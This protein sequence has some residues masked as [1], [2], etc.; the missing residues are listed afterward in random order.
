MRALLW[1]F[2]GLM[3]HGP[4][5]HADVFTVG[6][7]A[8]CTHASV[9]AAINA[10]LDNGNGLDVINVARN[11][12]Y[13]AQA[14]VAQNDTLVIQG[15]FTDCS[16]ATGDPNLPTVISGAG[17]SAAP[18]LRIQGNGNVT[19]RNLVL[20]DGDAPANADGGGLSI[21]DGPHLITL[22]NVRLANN[23][24]GRGAGMAVAS[25]MASVTVTLQG[26]SRIFGNQASSDGGGIY[27]LNSNLSLVTESGI[28]NSN[29]SGRDGGGIYAENCHTD[30]ASGNA[31]GLLWNNQSVRNG[32]GIYAFGSFSVTRVYSLFA[33]A[34]TRLGANV[35]AASGGAIYA[36]D[37]ADVQLQNIEIADNTAQDGGGIFYRGSS[38]SVG[39]DLTIASTGVADG[40]VDC[41]LGS[42]CNRFVDNYSAVGGVPADGVAAI[43]WR[44]EGSA[45]GRA[46]INRASFSGNQGGRVLDSFVQ[47]DAVTKQ[48]ALSNVVLVGNQQTDAQ[49]A[50]IQGQKL[51]LNFVSIGGNTLAGEAVI[52]GL[53]L[54]TVLGYVA[55]YQ[56]GSPLLRQVGGSVLSGYLIANDL[57]GIPPTVNNLEADPRFAGV[58][59][60]HL[61]RDSP[62]IDYATSSS[63]LGW[64][65]N[66]DAEGSL[67]PLDDSGITNQFGS[68]DVGAFES[69]T[70]ALFADGFDS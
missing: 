51:V 61:R 57:S 48:M 59:D 17:G 6:S 4:G 25:N 36:A 24:A 11:R 67:R 31:L 37:G 16:S 5:A 60:L 50:L 15:G 41:P 47:S 64:P 27:C 68:I 56:P 43:A 63:A 45:S 21:I 26:E 52:R 30:L 19:L 58:A 39:N 29:T 34:L 53:D 1:C 38:G 12:T 10:G 23:Q 9:Q 65:Y 18:V 32:G 20:Q 3:L 13:T 28:I 69:A 44:L 70:D 49:A 22:N 55:A 54:Q 14:L 62:A 66:A 2:C 46:Q 42:I 35:A 40:A 8:A 7:G 33:D